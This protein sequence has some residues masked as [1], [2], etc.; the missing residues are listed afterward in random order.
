MSLERR[1]RAQGAMGARGGAGQ[2]R[3][4]PVTAEEQ[5]EAWI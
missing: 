5:I 2:K 3:A 1:E 4:W